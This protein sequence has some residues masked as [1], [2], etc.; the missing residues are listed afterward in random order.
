MI[1]PW[2]DAVPD[3]HEVLLTL[4]LPLDLT[5]FG[6]LMGGVREA[7]ERAGYTDVALLGDGSNRVVGRKAVAS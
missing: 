3:G 5:L 2:D 1:T 6:E 7:A 4:A